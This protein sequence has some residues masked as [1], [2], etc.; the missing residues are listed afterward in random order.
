MLDAAEES[1]YRV[2]FS[3]ALHVDAEAPLTY[4]SPATLEAD[5]SFGALPI[6]SAPG[7]DVIEERAA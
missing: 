1:R 2:R 6:D 5:H 7:A 4:L 3:D